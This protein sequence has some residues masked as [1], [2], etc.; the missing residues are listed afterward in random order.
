LDVGLCI[1]GR[2]MHHTSTPLISPAGQ[3]A[4]VL[5]GCTDDVRAL[6]SLHCG[7]LAGAS[8][9]AVLLWDAE[10][11]GAHNTMDGNAAMQ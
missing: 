7:W 9:K 8:G 10:T 1:A 5:Q 2:T 4:L 11:G 3:C 6:V